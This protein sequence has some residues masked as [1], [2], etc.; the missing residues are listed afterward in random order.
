MSGLRKTLGLPSLVV[1]GIGSMIGAGIYS[2]IGP[3]AIISGNNLWISFIL[4]SVAAAITVLSY[5]ELSSMYPK[6]GAEFQFLKH[7]FPNMPYLSFMAGFLIALNA[8]ATSATVS[9]AFAGYLKIFI[10]NNE[11]ITALGLLVACTVINIIGIKQS[12]WTN[13]FLVIIEVSG[14]L[15]I[16]WSG[17]KKGDFHKPFQDLS[18]IRSQ[19][20]SGILSVTALIFF[21]YIGFEDVANLSEE[22]N[23]PLHV[24][25]KALIYSVIITSIIYILVAFSFIMLADTNTYYTSSPL[26][27]AVNSVS[28]YGGLYVGIAALFATAS[29]ALISL[30][31]ISRMIYAMANES[32]MPKIFSF[33]LP[34]RKTP[35]VAAL[36][37]FIWSALLLLLGN[38]S[39]IASVSSMGVLIVFMFVQFA[40]ITLRFTQKNQNR[41]FKTPFNYKGVSILPIVGVLIILLLL[42]QFPIKIYWIVGIT[43]IIGTIIY[44]ARYI[45]RYVPM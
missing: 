40:L 34:A 24:V 44:F 29:T 8:S 14:L 4:A 25:P 11:F 12:T 10:A 19:G 15:V 9:L 7:A 26:S 27:V 1:Y 31:S 43:I 35:W 30:V 18:I 28:S 38:I 6:A 2:I 33:I 21:V 32:A 22:T 17:F 16:I 3:A 45:K 42:T 13:I 23:D 5:A 39:S 41:N 36:F 37:L 20:I